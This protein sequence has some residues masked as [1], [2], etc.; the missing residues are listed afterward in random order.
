MNPPHISLIWLAFVFVGCT[1]PYTPG[2]TDFPP[3]S[4][5]DFT[6]TSPIT[7]LNNQPSS[8]ESLFAQDSSNKFVGNYQEWT[9]TA[10]TMTRTEIEKH[11]I[12][13]QEDAEKKLKLSIT[14]AHC[15]IGMY[16]VNCTT[17]LI[18]ETG[19]GYS[20]RYEQSNRSPLGVYRAVDGALMFSVTAMFKDEKF[21]D[22]L[23]E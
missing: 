8:E 9:E 17:I 7:L 14:H 20:G 15:D 12:P 1:F 2:P 6:S 5:Q 19:H 4:I 10:L 3:D 13:V 22:Y 23:K 11:R 16:L 18:A 21:I